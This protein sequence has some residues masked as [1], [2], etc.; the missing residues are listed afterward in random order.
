[1]DAL[2]GSEKGDLFNA[3]DFVSL[4]GTK[5]ATLTGIDSLDGGEGKDTLNVKSDN[6]FDAVSATIKNIETINLESGAAIGTG[7]GGAFD[8]TTFTGVETLNVTKATAADLI[9]AAT[10]DVNVSGV[11]GDIEVTNGKNVV[12]NDNTV[13]TDIIVNGAAGTIT[14]T[15]TKNAGTAGTDDITIDGGTNVTVTAT[16][17][18]SSGNIEI[19]T[20]KQATGDVK[21]TQNLNSDGT[22]ALNAGTIKVTGGKTVDVTVNSTI[23]AK[24]VTATNNITNGNVTV[25]SDGKTTT[26]TVSQNSTVTEFVTAET[27]LVNGKTAITFKAM[28]A[29]QALS[30][31]G[32]SFHATKNLTASEVAAAFANLTNSDTQSATGTTANGYYTGALATAGL[33]T[34]AAN[35]AVVEFIS[36]NNTPVAF[37]AANFAG[38]GAGKMVGYLT[39]DNSEVNAIEPDAPTTTAGTAFVAESDTNN[40]VIYGDVIVDEKT[41]VAASI[42]TITLDGFDD[43][44]LGGNNALNALTTLSIANS[45]GTTTLKTTKT[46]LTLNVDN[47][48]SAVDLDDSAAAITTLTIN[49]NG[50][51]SDFDLTAA[52]VETLT[53]AA[54]ADLDLDNGSTLSAL[55][56]VTITGAGDVTLGNISTTATSLT[57][58][59]TGDVSVTVDGTKATVTTGSGNDTIT[60][61]NA[62]AISKAINLGDGDDTLILAAGTTA[63]PTAAVAGGNGTDTISMTTIS[64]EA[65]D[66][67]TNFAAAISG[68]ER[69]IISNATAATIEADNLGFNYVTFG[70]AAT[71]ILNDVAANSTTVLEAA[72][73]NLAIV[74]DDATGEADVANVVVNNK[75]A[76]TAVYTINLTGAASTAIGQTL[77]VGG[78]LLYTATANNDNAAAIATAI[79]GDTIVIGGVEYLIDATNPAA[80]TL[81]AQT[82]VTISETSLRIDGTATLPTNA[83]A[84][85]AAF[86]VDFGTVTIAGVET[87]NLTSSD[88]TTSVVSVVDENTLIV[89][90]DTAKTI[91]IDGAADLDLST[92]AANLK[93]VDASTMTGDLTVTASNASMT[94]KG[95]AGNDIITIAAT[96]D[97][98]K[99]Y[100]NAGNDTFKIAASADLIT[101]DGGA[102]ADTFD[103]NGVSTN[104]SNFVV[105]NNVDSGDILDLA[106]F[107]ATTFNSTKITLSVGATETTQAYLDQAMTTLSAGQ[108]GWFQLNGNT[109]VTADVGGESANSFV[110]GQDFVVM[111]TGLKD[112]STASFNTDTDTLVIA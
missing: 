38:I 55:K 73:N 7:A 34:G 94:V 107:S 100:G 102:G 13:N 19:G 39:S 50:E 65:Y 47:I 81:T 61:S 31:D 41:A 85:T 24:N 8:T 1:M 46:A 68:F 42:T 2:V 56:T 35:G 14:V 16:A 105:L 28:T 21:V 10:T 12:V 48:T 32:L 86:D 90:A 64:A 59:T 29:G 3:Y 54:A 76:N 97:G 71:G 111:I 4:N 109:Y 103:F 23:T 45:A 104:K 70:G 108:V 9:A 63:I 101:I 110:D 27:A 93:T 17:D 58:T 30:I 37:A 60:L 78:V 112:L 84:T 20:T 33:T 11:T 75:S 25:N 44:D 72:G 106:A 92:T 91:N 57:S 95:G 18:A 83:T 5:I 36:A 74:L 77:T 6:A 99:F 96:A 88:A 53:I 62:A 66:A 67:N 80:V 69:L 52:K 98:S 51:A 87:I 49:A 43:A 22:A 89:V 79:D 15:D 82:D 40:S 26:V